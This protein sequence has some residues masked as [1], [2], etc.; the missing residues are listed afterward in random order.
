MSKEDFKKDGY[1]V[2][3]NAVN[4]DLADFITQYAL[5][6]EMQDFKS[7]EMQGYTQV[8]KAHSKYGD[9]AME[10]LLLTLQPIIEQ[11][12]GLKVYPTYSFYRVYRPGDEL[13]PHIDRPSCEISITVSLGNDYQGKDYSW[14]IYINGTDCHLSV[15]DLVCYRGVDL[16]HWRTPFEAPEGSWHVQAFL[17]YVDINGPYAEWKW[18]KRT[19][20][21]AIGELR[22]QK[23]IDKP[24]I[25]R[26]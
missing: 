17:H 2:V 15:G 18:D 10:T 11:N 8:P 13:L 7:E 6:D 23:T 19:S 1:I 3:K 20:I 16:E 5:F 24:Y 25:I 12:T 4:K 21:G 22:D 26:S 14:P 9:P